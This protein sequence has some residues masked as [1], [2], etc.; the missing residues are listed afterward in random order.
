[1]ASDFK[2]GTTSGG[3]TSL[4]ALGTPVPNPQP[5]FA[6]YRK[7]SKLANGTM[8]GRGPQ[9]IVWAFPL[10]DVTE[11]AMLETFQSTS[12]IYIQ[13]RKRDDSLGIFQ[14]LMNWLEPNEDGEHMAGFYGYRGGLVL[15]F[16]VISEVV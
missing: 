10:I 6:K 15:E 11:I 7:K 5:Q 1:M 13:S 14:V 4:D 3:I 2:I 8:K 9:V 16:I 12:P